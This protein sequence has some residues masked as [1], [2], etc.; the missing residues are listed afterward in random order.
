MGKTWV[1]RRS[2]EEFRTLDA[3]LH[4]CIY[5]RRYSQ[6]LALPAL[7]EIGDRAE[8]RIFWIEVIRLLGLGSGHW[9]RFQ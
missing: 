6:L 8:R 2:Y 4:Q 5:D 3:H 9:S 7:C 1:V